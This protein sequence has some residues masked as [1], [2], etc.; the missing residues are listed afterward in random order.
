[1]LPG[2]KPLQA[3]LVAI[4]GGYVWFKKYLAKE[5]NTAF[6]DFRVFVIKQFRRIKLQ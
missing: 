4:I 2:F 3:L 6:I 1:V 5:S